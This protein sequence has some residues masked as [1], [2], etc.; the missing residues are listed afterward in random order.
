MN[1]HLAKVYLLC[2]RVQWVFGITEEIFPN[3]ALAE[4]LHVSVISI[5]ATP[6]LVKLED[7]DWLVGAGFLA[8]ELPCHVVA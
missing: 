4:L 2:M 8:I 7:H 5:Y 6:G 1:D 3:L